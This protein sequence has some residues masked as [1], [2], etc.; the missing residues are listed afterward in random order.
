MNKACHHVLIRSKGAECSNFVP[1]EEAAVSLHLSTEDS[2]RFARDF[3][4]G[5]G[6]TKRLIRLRGKLLGNT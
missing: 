5:H 4:C 2:S 3:W 6:F 1:Y